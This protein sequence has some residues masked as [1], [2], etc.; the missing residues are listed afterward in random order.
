MIEKSNYDKTYKQID[1]SKFNLAGIEFDNCQFLDCSFLNCNLGDTDF[2]ECQFENCNFITTKTANTGFKDVKFKGCK[3]VGL[4]FSMCNNF[5]FEVEF[6]SSQLDYALFSKK[7]MRK[8]RFIK[9]SVKEADF[10]ETNLT[11]A[12]FENSD[13]TGSFFDRCNLEKTD[14]RAAA[15]FN[16]DPD[17][18]RMKGAKFASTEL[19]GLLSKYG[20]KI[21]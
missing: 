14:F 17:K 13:L 7:N 18:N 21:Y 5:L 2:L 16:I 12:T 15:N 19:A 1:F 6:E 9:C 3:L 10:S 4:D 8:T 11:E 20:L